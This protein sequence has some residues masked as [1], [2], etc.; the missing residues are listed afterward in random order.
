MP[1]KNQTRSRASSSFI[2]VCSAIA[3]S[4]LNT[5]NGVATPA[6]HYMNPIPGYCR[7]KL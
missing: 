2:T 1:W 5:W 4:E 3:T 6:G 7:L